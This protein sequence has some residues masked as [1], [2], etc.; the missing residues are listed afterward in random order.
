MRFFLFWISAFL[1]GAVAWSGILTVVDSAGI[2]PLPVPL[3]MIDAMDLLSSSMDRRS[4]DSKVLFLGD[5]TTIDFPPAIQEL[6]NSDRQRRILIEPFTIPGETPF[7]QYFLSRAL[8][9]TKPDAVILSVNLAAFSRTFATRFGKVELIG[10]LG[11]ARFLDAASLPLHWLNATL[12]QVVLSMFVA[13]SGGM[14]LW[15]DL[16]VEQARVGKLTESI[17]DWLRDVRGISPDEY[18]DAMGVVADR[19][20]IVTKGRNRLSRDGSIRVYGAALAGLPTD[21]PVLDLYGRLLSA[22][23]AADIP[24]LMYVLPSDIE[25]LRELDLVDEAA[26]ELTMTRIGD[27]AR[28]HAALFADLHDLLPDKFYVD[29]GGHFKPVDGEDPTSMVVQRLLPLVEKLVKGN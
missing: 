11:P 20:A 8:I 12:D 3:N 2:K 29:A 5:S 26:L 1:G 24:V 10:L 21:H 6:L 17:E 27:L 4:D 19:E 14:K 7:D 16:R 18:S 25:Y 15:R 28:A 13:Q 9:D 23:S 22:F